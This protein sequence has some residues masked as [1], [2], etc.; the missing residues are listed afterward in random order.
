MEDGTARI[1]MHQ[2]RKALSSRG[3][4]RRTLPV[5]DC[6]KFE[7]DEGPGLQGNILVTLARRMWSRRRVRR[8]YLRYCAR[9]VRIISRFGH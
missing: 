5:S 7:C 9:S 4:A 2:E 8:V 6:R 3:E 1:C